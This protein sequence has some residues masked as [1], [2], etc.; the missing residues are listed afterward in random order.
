MHKYITNC[1]TFVHPFLS[2]YL[3]EILF[4]FAHC[5]VN[6]Y[7]NCRLDLVGEIKQNHLVFATGL[8][9]CSLFYTDYQNLCG[10]IYPGY[11]L[12]SYN[13]LMFTENMNKY[14]YKLIVYMA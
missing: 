9:K 1:L 6:V 7:F 8:I 3:L 5:F 2:L 13:V 10:Y 12:L 4:N 14:A 11:T